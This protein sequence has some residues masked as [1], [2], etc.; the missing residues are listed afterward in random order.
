MVSRP[1]LPFEV[2]FVKLT[3][4]LDNY[5]SR[6]FEALEIDYLTESL[7]I[8]RGEGFTTFDAF[9][10]GYTEIHKVTEGFRKLDPDRLFE[11]IR[12]VPM[13]LVVLRT[14]L[15]LSPPEWAGVAT[16]ATGEQINQGFARNLERAIRRDPGKRIGHT[17]LQEARIRALVHAA[18]QMLSQ[19]APISREREIPRLD[20][21]DTVHGMESLSK[22]AREGVDYP[23]LLY[24]R[25]LGRP[26]AS[27]RDSVSEL[28]GAPLEDKIQDQLAAKQIP[29]HR[30]GRAES[31]EGWDQNP[32]FFCPDPEVPAAVIEAKMTNDDGTARDKVARVLRL[33]EIRNS[34]E[35]EYKPG[36]DVIACIGGRGFGVR[37][38]DMRSLLIATRGKVF[39]L[40]Q[41]DRIVECTALAH[42]K[43]R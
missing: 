2:S 12:R 14:I 28:V 42:R 7:A 19:S 26:F 1:S 36:F 30:T 32:D 4:N 15:G 9:V 6:V 5:V 27:H 10:Q 31:L 40:S 25:L 20:K 22:V 29:F 41:I 13:A 38:A 18:C 21:V 24:E 33:A 34:R 3:D 23:S 11:A 8:P 39:T 16:I 35:L 43:P 17:P 37:K